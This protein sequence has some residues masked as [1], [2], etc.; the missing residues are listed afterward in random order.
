MKSRLTILS[1]IVI[2]IIA[3]TS[4]QKP[5]QEE[6]YVELKPSESAVVI[7]LEQGTEKQQQTKSLEYLKDHK[8]Y[9]KRIP[10]PTKWHQTGHMTNTGNWI[11][12]VSVIVVNRAPITREWTKEPATGTSSKDQVIT[13][14]SQNSI[15]FYFGITCT[16]SII[17][18]DVPLYLYWYGQKTIEQVMDE[19]VRSYVQDYCTNEFGKRQLSNCQNE[20][21]DVFSGMK[22]NVK[23]HFA[24]RGLRIDNIGVAGEFTY[25]NGEIQTA[26]NSEFISQKREAAAKHDVAAAKEYQQ[27]GEAI[28]S[29]KLLEAQVNLINSTAEGLRTGKLIPPSTLVIGSTSDLTNL[30]GVRSAASNSKH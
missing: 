19:N 9:V 15:G 7:P 3:G 25:L 2:V 13:V 20:R 18:E 1:F 21:T 8:A 4:C 22:E 29:Q 12:T 14:E 30:M 6:L 17:D 26:I 11:P 5:Y 27:A 16:A 23:K 10:V 28:K 24:E